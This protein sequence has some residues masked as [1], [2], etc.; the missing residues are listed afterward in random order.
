VAVLPIASTG[1][2]FADNRRILV[3]I[4]E[5]SEILGRGVEVILREAPEMW[6]VDF[7]DMADRRATSS[8]PQV[9][10]FDADLV[11]LS[12]IAALANLAPS[13]GLVGLCARRA[14]VRSNRPE[15][16]Q[17]LSKDASAAELRIAVQAAAGRL[18]S[19]AGA[20]QPLTPRERQIL[21]LLL[22]NMTHAQMA[23]RLHITVETARSHTASIRRKTGA[24]SNRALRERY[25]RE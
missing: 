13:V 24:S 15:P 7:S 21:D 6:L 1:S 23:A 3:A 9:I 10:I 16:A 18:S 11:N 20:P 12:Q 22:A 19:V 2:S 17:L 25:T 4:G 8:T 14:N 5:C